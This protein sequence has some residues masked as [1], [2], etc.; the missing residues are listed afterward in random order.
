MID[1][2]SPSYGGWRSIISLSSSANGFV[3]LNRKLPV[4]RH[5]SNCSTESSSS[6]G[7]THNCSPVT[8]TVLASSHSAPVM[9]SVQRNV[10]VSD[11]SNR[12]GIFV[13][14]VIDAS[15]D[16]VVIG[17]VTLHSDSAPM[18][19]QSFSKAIVRLL[20]LTLLAVGSIIPVLATLKHTTCD[21]SDSTSHS[22]A[23][24]VCLRPKN[25]TVRSININDSP[26][27]KVV[28]HNAKLPLLG[29]ALHAAADAGAVARMH[30]VSTASMASTS[31][32]T[33]LI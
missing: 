14:N 11:L 18:R 5:S 8:F 33:I 21:F 20:I 17:S 12:S 1:H 29:S 15:I 6:A 3:P 4:F 26:V 2:L 28:M 19:W 23:V 16:A 13:S 27:L 30:T 9:C 24:F 10:P 22:A 32:L 31:S 7:A 25:P